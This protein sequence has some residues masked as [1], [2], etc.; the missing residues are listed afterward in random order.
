MSEPTPPGTEPGE[1]QDPESLVG[2]VLA[3]RYRLVRLL[4]WGAMGAVYVGE[5]LKIG[6]R[7]AIKVLR[8][9]L[10]RDPDTVARFARGARNASAIR[11]P[12]VCTVYDFSDTSEG[13]QFLAME[14]VDGESLTEL[15]EREGPLPLERAAR[16]AIQAASALEAAHDL[17]IVHRDVKP[18]NIMITRDRD[19]ADLAKVVDFDIAKGSAEGEKKGVTRLG[20]VVGTPEYM[21]PEQ[22]TGDPLDGRSDLYSLAL[23]FFRMVTG[24]LPYRST[25]TQELMVDRLTR[26]PMKLAEVAPE[27]SFSQALQTV[28]DRA[29][30]RNRGN[31]PAD[32]REFANELWDAV[33][34][35][36]ATTGE[37]A[38]VDTSLGTAEPDF[39]PAEVP[40][41]VTPPVEV[42][43]TIV[44][45]RGEPAR[46]GRPTTGHPEGSRRRMVG[47]G[48]AGAS[49]IVVG[50]LAIAI[51]SRPGPKPAK[52]TVASTPPL[53]VGESASMKA[54]ILDAR[55]AILSGVDVRWTST[56]PDVASVDAGGT[57]RALQAGNATIRAAVGSVHGETQVTVSAPVVLAPPQLGRRALRFVVPPGGGKPKADSVKVTGTSAAGRSLTSDVAYPVGS[58]RGWLSAR[59]EGTGPPTTVVVEPTR[60]PSSPGPYSASVVVGWDGGGPAD[61]IQVT[62]DVQRAATQPPPQPPERRLTP[63]QA[64]D[65]AWKQAWNQFTI[66]GSHTDDKSRR[67]VLD[68]TR[69]LW[70]ARYLPDSTRALAAW[71][72]AQA[73]AD[74]GEKEECLQWADS[75]LRLAPTSKGYRALLSGGCGRTRDEGRPRDGR[76]GHGPRS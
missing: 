6:R 36:A 8:G 70:E 34:G 18:D 52:V 12:N 57:V 28:M 62:L 49:I 20:F 48:L 41:Q 46:A 40:A 65:R 76:A 4:G 51:L 5:H 11:H 3:G 17:G 61:T 53:T 56:R 32:A 39:S 67:A 43:P 75:A 60:P 19:G 35:E 14:L 50:G 54:T 42:P 58:A 9:S 71:V 64:S 22:L 27:G 55:G 26:D 2:T 29:L 10:A 47:L 59:L 7:D 30:A 38:E 66:L 69:I 45:P 37:V 21:S 24:G 74:L 68:T 15:L 16:I 63:K 23:V 1:G 25:S 13:L 31:R 72:R 44:A 73:A 33:Y